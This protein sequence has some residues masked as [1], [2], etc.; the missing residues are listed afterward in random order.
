MG[1][2]V[3]DNGQLQD[4]QEM[5]GSAWMTVFIGMDK[6]TGGPTIIWTHTDNDLIKGLIRVTT[7]RWHCYCRKVT[8]D[9]DIVTNMCMSSDID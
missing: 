4:E 6:G 2:Q 3:D 7:S 8:T 5:R 9:E 1:K